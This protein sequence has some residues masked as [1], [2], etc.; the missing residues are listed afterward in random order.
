ML[1]V[2]VVVVS[3]E[4]DGCKSG[5]NGRSCVCRGLVVVIVLMGVVIVEVG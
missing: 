2:V 3:A 5:G 1:V 4:K